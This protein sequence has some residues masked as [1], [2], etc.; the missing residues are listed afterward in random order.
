MNVIN[1][2]ATTEGQLR[3]IN[4][5]IHDKWFDVDDVEHDESRR[6]VK[7]IVLDVF[8][9]SSISRAFR[10]TGLSEKGT[11]GTLI[12][13]HCRALRIDDTEEIGRYDINRL[14]YEAAGGTLTL[15]TNTPLGFQL[16]VDA[17]DVSLVADHAIS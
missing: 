14:R 1:M 17:L 5:L 10:D 9:S 4:D 2:H 13:D 8:A 6:R 11:R 15:E 3:M 7:V 12:I 16:D